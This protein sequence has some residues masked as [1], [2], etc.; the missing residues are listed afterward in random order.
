MHLGLN[1]K[2]RTAKRFRN[3]S[4]IWKMKNITY[5]LRL[6]KYFNTDIPGITN[7]IS[8]IKYSRIIL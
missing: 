8:E 4:Y 1:N 5:F 6:R 2:E 3:S 7:K